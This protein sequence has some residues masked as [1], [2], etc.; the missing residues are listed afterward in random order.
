MTSPGASTNNQNPPPRVISA[1]AYPRDPKYY[2]PDGSGVF[3]VEG[4]LFKIQATLIFGPRP[5]PPTR[6]PEAS[7]PVYL[8]DIIPRL[9]NSNDSSPIEIPGIR[10]SQFRDYFLILLGRP[11]DDDYLKLVTSSRNP[12]KYTK[13]LCIRYLDIATLARCFGMTKLEEW[14][15]DAL[16]SIFTRS[17]G[18]LTRIASENWDSSTVLRLRA[19]TKD[20]KLNLPVLTF[21]QYLI[22][23]SSKDPAVYAM[24]GDRINELPCV[25][26]Y[27]NFKASDAESV[28]FGCAFLNILSLGHRSQVW[29]KCLTRDDRALLY[30]AQA[31][32]VNVSAELDLDLGWIS[33]PDSTISRQFCDRCKTMIPEK[34]E[35]GFGEC[36]KALGSG[37]PL[38]DVSL[39]A[40]LPL[41]RHS[42]SQQP[43]CYI[44]LLDAVDANIKQVFTKMAS[45]H[46][47]IVE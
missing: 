28:L 10:A 5:V 3:L 30:A 47:E 19:F 31:Q 37:L 45:K 11:Y 35:K 44:A 36:N 12:D 40:Q 21:I 9:L 2:F 24:L 22:S 42:C 38:K 33:A 26:L 25:G 18:A 32:L 43:A 7:S 34:W 27:Q 1:L 20:T 15:I 6:Q 23:N 14:V 39:L 16:H 8:E 4:I 29:A 46:R 41:H 17:I 13:G